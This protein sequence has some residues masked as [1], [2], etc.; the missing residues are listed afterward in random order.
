M[1][2]ELTSLREAL[3]QHGKSTARLE[4]STSSLESRIGDLDARAVAS[5]HTGRLDH[6]AAQLADLDARVTAVATELANQ[7]TELGNDIDGRPP[8]DG[9]DVTVVG[10]L[11]D[12]QVRLAT[13]QA[14]YQIAFRED[15]ARLAEQLRRPLP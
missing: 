10:E 11:R 14:R 6:L 8:A 9:A 5:D 7:I 3:E 12:G 2:A 4:A 15:L 1:R 13:E